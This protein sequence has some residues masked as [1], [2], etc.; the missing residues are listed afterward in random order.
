MSRSFKRRVLAAALAG[1]LPFG[2]AQG[3]NHR[4]A[5]I[6]ALDEKADIT[7]VYA[8][9]SYDDPSKVTMILNVDPLLEP[10]NGPTYF[11]FDPEIVYELKVDNDHDAVEDL[12]FQFRFRTEQRLGGLFTVF[13]GAGDG[14]AAPPSS[15]APVPPGAIVVPPAITALDGPG[16]EGL[17]QRQTYSVTMVQGASRFAPSVRLA[18][19]LIAV[20]TNAGPRTMPNYAAL[21]SQG[22]YDLDD[23]VRV[24]AGTV[25]DPFWIDLGA[26]FDTLN[27]RQGA[28]GVAVSGV[29]GDDQDTRDDVNFASDDVAGFNVNAIAIEVPIEMLTADGEL[30]DADDPLATIGVW[31]TTS[32][33]RVKVYSRRPGGAARTSTSVVQIQRMANPLI[34]ELLIGVGSKDKFSMSQPKDD[35][36]FSSFVLDPVIAR[37]LNAAV[38]AG[39]GAD[40]LPIPDAPR[41]DLL[42]LVQYLPPIAAPST[43]PGP[44]ADLLR[45]NTGIGPTPPSQRSRLGLLTLLDGDT[46]NDDPAGFP[47]GRRVSDDVVDIVARAAVGVLSGDPAFS[48]FPHNRI[49]DGVNTN[50]VEYPETFPYLAF[51][52]SGRNS[53]HVDPGED[54][55]ADPFAPGSPV[56]CPLD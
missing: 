49:G 31:G 9:V 12:R 20:P 42:P 41:L 40:V 53:A 52:Q 16:S 29:L 26:A 48:S 45:L 3:A 36:Q 2:V 23:E 38:F 37:A 28:S 1:L 51:A 30:H 32:R 7:D 46:G 47:N 55:C 15:P 8:F 27:F 5:P 33:P 10:S 54:G 24:F 56:P 34:N 6:T 4:E 25:D 39:L 44:V 19:D 35:S 43:P 13:A 18:D 17:G 11:P 14:L 22:I 50:D 21:A